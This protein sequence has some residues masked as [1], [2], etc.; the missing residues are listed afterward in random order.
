MRENT[1][2]AL[3]KERSY[4]RYSMFCIIYPRY[5]MP[6]TSSKGHTLYYSIS[7]RLHL[8]TRTRVSKIQ[9]TLFS[10]GFYTPRSMSPLNNE[11]YHRGRVS[12]VADTKLILPTDRTP[13]PTTRFNSWCRTRILYNWIRPRLSFMTPLSDDFSCRLLSKFLDLACLQ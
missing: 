11:T 12:R 8:C 2:H 9:R 5:I 13:H 7:N 10:H 6:F 3:T 4:P 1:F